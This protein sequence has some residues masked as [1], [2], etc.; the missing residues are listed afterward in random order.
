MLF[1]NEASGTMKPSQI[2]TANP[3]PPP[4]SQPPPTKSQIII[5]CHF[6]GC[7]SYGHQETGV[8]AD[9][10]P[11]DPTKVEVYPGGAIINFCSHGGPTLFIRLSVKTDGVQVEHVLKE[12]SRPQYEIET[13]EFELNNRYQ[14]LCKLMGLLM[15]LLRG[16]ILKHKPMNVDGCVWAM[17]EVARKASAVT[18]AFIELKFSNAALLDALTNLEKRPYNATDPGLKSPM[19]HNILQCSSQEHT[20]RRILTAYARHNPFVGYCQAMSFFA[21]LL[22]TADA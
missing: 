15:K 7:A 6:G 14:S 18:R 9:G 4:K 22:H 8:T 16:R 3:P 19:F 13:Y 17:I 10:L 1:I 11:T 21:G 2:T 12:Y 20:L 5:F